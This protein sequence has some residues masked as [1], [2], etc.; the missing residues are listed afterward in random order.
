M[1][2]NRLVRE[3]LVNFELAK[4]V[5]NTIGDFYQTNF[6]LI[7]KEYNTIYYVPTYEEV[8]DH[9]EKTD[10]F[11]ITFDV[12]KQFSC[13]YKWYIFSKDKKYS[14]FKFYCSE[15][16]AWEAAIKYYCTYLLN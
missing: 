12:V 16:C 4:L 15:R 2:T 7:D 1:I 3:S 6:K 10:E 14:D 9:I 11:I 5:Q 8:I 13:G